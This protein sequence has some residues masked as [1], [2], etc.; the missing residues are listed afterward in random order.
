MI[1]MDE[2]ECIK[3]KKTPDKLAYQR[4]IFSPNS[5]HIVA[6]GGRN[7]HDQVEEAIKN[8][9]YIAICPSREDFEVYNSSFTILGK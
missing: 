6:V 4:G 2:A 9:G 1:S 7:V 5:N 8:R 3:R